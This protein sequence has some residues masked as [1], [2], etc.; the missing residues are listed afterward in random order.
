M[1][2]KSSR[3][4]LTHKGHLV[5][6]NPSQAFS[7]EEQQAIRQFLRTFG[8]KPGPVP[9]RLKPLLKGG[10]HS[11][12][13]VPSLVMQKLAQQGSLALNRRGKIVWRIPGKA[14][15]DFPHPPLDMDNQRFLRKR[16]A[17]II[18]AIRV[19]QILPPSLAFKKAMATRQD[20]AA[21]VRAEVF[22]LH[23]RYADRGRAKAS[24]IAKALKITPR[25]IRQILA[26]LTQ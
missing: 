22:R 15:A 13:T 9:A 23:E 16:Q 8:L 21:R 20:K 7:A 11:K 1:S 19:W 18:K 25:R 24:L 3:A 4:H 12:A 17:E 2:R 10:R 26:S 5:A 6:D 14:G